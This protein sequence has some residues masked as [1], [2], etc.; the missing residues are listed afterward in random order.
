MKRISKNKP[1]PLLCLPL[2]TNSKFLSALL[3]ICIL[4]A[5]SA[6]AGDSNQTGHITRV[7]Y[8]TTGVLIMLDVGPPTNFSATPYGWMMIAPQYT[9]MIAF[10]TVCG[11]VVTRRRNSWL[12]T[13]AALT[14]R[15]TAKSTKAIQRG[16]DKEEIYARRIGSLRPSP[17]FD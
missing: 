7:S 11:F 12:F 5:F 3:S 13:R 1:L 10:V 17:Y 16:L 14:A 2:L 9:A 15:G 8:A 4:G 6:Q